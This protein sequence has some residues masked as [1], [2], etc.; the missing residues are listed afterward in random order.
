MTEKIEL[1]TTTNKIPKSFNPTNRIA[2]GTH[3]MLGNDCKPTANE[4]IVLPKSL[5]LTI[6]NPIPIPRIMEIENPVTSLH[7]VIP[8]LMNSEPLKSKSAKD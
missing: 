7:I 8:M 3:A 6:N 5:N 1:M 4:L 2:N